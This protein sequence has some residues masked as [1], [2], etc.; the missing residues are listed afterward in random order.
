MPE[1]KNAHLLG[2]GLDGSDGHTRVTRAEDFSIVGGSDETHTR[3]TETLIR[4]F[5]DLGRRGRSLDKVEKK[6]LAELIA[7]NS[8]D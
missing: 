6:E 2:V 8:P 7:K 3:M 1:S 4:T 5:E